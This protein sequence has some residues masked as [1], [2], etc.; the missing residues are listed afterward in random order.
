[1]TD[2]GDIKVV[3][4][5]GSRVDIDSLRATPWRPPPSDL[6]PLARR[7]IWRRRP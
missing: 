4:S 6:H 5:D 1:M 3:K 7:L 2:N